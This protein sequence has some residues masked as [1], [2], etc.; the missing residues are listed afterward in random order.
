[1]DEELK[2]EEQAPKR[3]TLGLKLNASNSVLAK[4]IELLKS[5]SASA[6]AG[7]TTAEKKLVASKL[8]EQQLFKPQ[9]GSSGQFAA[10]TLSRRPS[11]SQKTR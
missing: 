1:M 11:Q 2:K 8:A 10:T 3:L 6:A 7:K 5:I 4:K 9:A